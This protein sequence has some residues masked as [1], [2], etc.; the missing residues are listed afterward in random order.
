INDN[1]FELG[2]DSILAIQIISRAN[3]AGIQITPKQ[4]FQH[5]TIA[6]LAAVGTQTPLIEAEQGII[7]GSVPLTPI[8]YWFFELQKPN[9]HHFNQ[10]VLLKVKTKLKLN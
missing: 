4:L 2:G 7:T 1:F 8:Q 9:P 3:Q 5:Q 6:E 10:A